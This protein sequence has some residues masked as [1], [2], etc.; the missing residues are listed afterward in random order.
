MS[1]RATAIGKHSASLQHS[2]CTDREVFCSFSLQK[3]VPSVHLSFLYQSL[4]NILASCH[5]KLNIFLA[6]QIKRGEDKASSRQNLRT[7]SMWSL[8]LAIVVTLSRPPFFISVCFYVLL[9]FPF[10]PSRK[11]CC[12]MPSPLFKPLLLTGWFFFFS[13]SY[14]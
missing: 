7:L 14:P 6:T 13:Q 12:L 10:T 4:D 11:E 8:N 2:L 1:L 5:V 9:F 3:P